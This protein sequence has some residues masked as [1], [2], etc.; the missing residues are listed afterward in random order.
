MEMSDIQIV[1]I[2]DHRSKYCTQVELV[3]NRFPEPLFEKRGKWL[4]GHDSGVFQFYGYERVEASWPSNWKAFGGRKIEIPM[5]GGGVTQASGQWW[6]SFPADYRG[7]V[8]S[9]GINTIERLEQCYVFMGAFHIDCAIVDEWRRNNEPSN[10]Y[11]KYDPRH[12]TFGQ[13]RITSKWE[14]TAA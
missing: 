9:H 4:I 6:D 8:Y 14:P 5:V 12:E 2:I 1:D 13:H 7:L 3:L 10:N 11:H